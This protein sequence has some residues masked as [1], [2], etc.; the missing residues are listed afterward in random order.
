M[1][2]ILHLLFNSPLLHDVDKDIEIALRKTISHSEKTT[3]VEI[4]NDSTYLITWT[5]LISH[6]IP[7]IFFFK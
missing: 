2:L 4:E 1:C 7:G 6:N 3:V 5:G